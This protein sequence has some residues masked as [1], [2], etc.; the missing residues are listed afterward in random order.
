M[1]TTPSFVFGPAA[2]SGSPA[3]Y[4]PTIMQGAAGGSGTTTA[5]NNYVNMQGVFSLMAMTASNNSISQVFVK[6]T[7]AG[8]VN[9]TDANGNPT[10]VFKI[11]NA[12][13]ATISANITPQTISNSNGSI[14]VNG[15]SYNTVGSLTVTVTAGNENAWMTDVAVGAVGLTAQ[16]ALS[17]FITSLVS[18]LATA[19]TTGMSSVAGGATAV[20]AEGEAVTAVSAESEGGAAAAEGGAAA[21]GGGEAAAGGAAVAEGIGIVAVAGFLVTLL[22][23]AAIVAA[24][25]AILHDS[26]HAVLVYNLT[27][28]NLAWTIPYQFEG[29]PYVLPSQSGSGTETVIPGGCPSGPN[30]VAKVMLYSSALFQ[31]E[32]N[33]SMTGIGY[34]MA[35]SLQNAGATIDT[36]NVAFDIPFEGDNS[37]TA[38]WGNIG[39]ASNFYNNM[40]GKNTNTAFSTKSADG[41]FVATVTYDYVSGEHPQPGN[42]NQSGYYYNSMIVIAQA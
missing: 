4:L 20:A 28:Y 21:A 13:A 23:V 11:S 6:M 14:V 38:A 27:P 25:C 3:S 7:N 37:L 17:G 8:W 35:F 15:K 2:G 1:S 12:A 5:I 33:S 19:I 30:G 9:G 40:E 32:S 29:S 22:V 41:K 31:F 26:Y 18:S 34:V 42:P 24:V 39:D 16:M 36:V 10:K